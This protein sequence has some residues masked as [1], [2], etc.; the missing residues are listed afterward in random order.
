MPI[1]TNLLY[2]GQAGIFQFYAPFNTAY[3]LDSDILYVESIE[4]IGQLIANNE[5]IFNTYFNPVGLSQTQYTSFLQSNGV[6]VGLKDSSGQRYFVPS[7]FI[8]GLPDPNGVPYRVLGL[9][10]VLGP[11]PTTFDITTLTNPLSGIV[12][13]IVGIPPS[14]NA[15]ELSKVKLIPTET[16]EQME[17]TRL[18]NVSGFNSVSYYLNQIEIA[19]QK[20][21]ALEQFI[22]NSL[23]TTPPQIAE[24]I[25]TGIQ[26]T[27]VENIT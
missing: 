8:Q 24:L 11:L 21:A 27:N 2:I 20:I 16:A 9:N 10:I 7:T 22:L 25:D 4:S 26:L 6:I 3:N 13:D 15:V 5:D 14:F 1:N 12:Y 23:S 19:Q 18:A 17:N